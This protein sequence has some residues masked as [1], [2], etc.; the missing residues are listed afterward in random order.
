[1]SPGARGHLQNALAQTMQLQATA[2]QAG[3]A[4]VLA[5][6]TTVYRVAIDWL[7]MAGVANPE[8]L[9]IDPDSEAAKKAQEASQKAA[10]EQQQMQMQLV[11]A[12]L[13]LER[14]KIR[15]QDKEAA[16][17][18]AHDYYDTDTRREIEEAKLAGNAVVQLETTRMTTE[19]HKASAEKRSTAAKA[20]GSN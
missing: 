20:V 5:S 14:L 1:M 2:M 15:Q 3:L 11:Q 8:R 4:G 9:W 13:E 6:P 19:A 10:Q 17:K 12:Q 7:R 16:G 18:L